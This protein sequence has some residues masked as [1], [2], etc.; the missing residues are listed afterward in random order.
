[1]FMQANRQRLS[2]DGLGIGLTLAR[3]LI[4]MHGG[5]IEVHSDGIGRGA[6]FRLKLPAEPC[7]AD[8]EP[9]PP[10]SVDSVALE[11]SLRVLVVDDNQDAAEMLVAMLSAWGQQTAV[12]YDGLQALAE[13]E[14]FTPDVVFLDIGMPGLD[15]YETARRLRQEPW[16]RHATIV[17]VTVWGQQTD[18]ERS[19]AAGFNHHLVKP[20]APAALRSLI[21]NCIEDLSPQR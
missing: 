8:V 16:G 19:Q 13:A 2:A 9:V 5:T 11:R 4:E 7:A 21:A 10:T 15:G 3:R 17:A 12:A 18:R 1:M 6:E 20:V 14:R